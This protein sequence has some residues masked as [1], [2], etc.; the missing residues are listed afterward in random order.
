MKKDL[1]NILGNFWKGQEKKSEIIKDFIVFSPIDIRTIEENFKKNI[2]SNSSI[3]EVKNSNR[4]EKTKSLL[5]SE[6]KKK[7]IE[8]DSKNREISKEIDKIRTEKSP[9]TPVKLQEIEE[10]LR[11]LSQ[12][13]YSF[14]TSIS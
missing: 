10:R 11:R 7:L 4:Y 6:T 3:R 9:V 8:M 2:Q 1:D 14:G 13:M 12:E 5:E